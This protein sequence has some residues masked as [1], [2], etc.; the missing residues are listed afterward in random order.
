MPE[1]Y[2]SSDRA[3][4]AKPYSDA[5]SPPQSLMGAYTSAQNQWTAGYGL[6]PQAWPPA[7][8]VQTQQWTPG[9]NQQVAYGGYGGSYTCPQ[10]PTSVAQGAVYDAYP[11]TY[12]A[13]AFPQQSYA[14]P[15]AA[16]TPAQQPASVPQPYY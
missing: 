6:Q 4:I 10:V 9:F 7:T 11:P 5:T 1:D 2:L 16:M 15:A 14:Q 3:K 8:Q 13:Q 12:P